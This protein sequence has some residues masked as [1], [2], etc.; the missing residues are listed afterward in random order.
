[1]VQKRWL[2][3]QRL[4]QLLG[5]NAIGFELQGGHELF[6]KKESGLLSTVFG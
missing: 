3:I 6:R 2:G 5:D 1:L 4:R